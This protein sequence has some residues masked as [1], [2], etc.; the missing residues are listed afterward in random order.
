MTILRVKLELAK[1]TQL[2]VTGETYELEEDV[3]NRP[4]PLSHCHALRIDHGVH[5]HELGVMKRHRTIVTEIV[6]TV[7]VVTEIA[8]DVAVIDVT[9]RD[10]D[11]TFRPMMMMIRTMKMTVTVLVMAVLR[12]VMDQI[13]RLEAVSDYV[14]NCKSLMVPDYGNLGGR[15]SETA[16]HIIDG[17]NEISWPFL[18]VL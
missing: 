14:S 7:T 1:A 8:V 4:I 5:S 13:R 10:E 12:K 3:T 6:R 17:W 9:V 11:K 18:K 15:I 2:V 16:H